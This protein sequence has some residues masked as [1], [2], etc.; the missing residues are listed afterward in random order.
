[1]LK[2]PFTCYIYLINYSNFT[3]T[4]S[5]VV[6]FNQLLG[7]VLCW[8]LYIPASSCVLFTI[9]IISCNDT[10]KFNLVEKASKFQKNLEKFPLFYL[11][12]WPFE[13]SPS[14]WKAW[15]SVTICGWKG[16]L[17]FFPLIGNPIKIRTL[18]GPLLI[19]MQFLK[20]HPCHFPV[21]ALSFVVLIYLSV[22][23]YIC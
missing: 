6:Y 11:L 15:L 13:R 5:K 21:M 4:S 10:T 16:N 7:A 12:L 9:H 22:F 19:S 18:I 3:L 23:Q 8:R 20:W 1:M 14:N 2:L 17:P